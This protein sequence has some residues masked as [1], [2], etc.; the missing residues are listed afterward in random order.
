MQNVIIKKRQR[1]QQTQAT[2]DKIREA[3][4]RIGHRPPSQK[5]LKRS[6]ESRERISLSKKGFTHTLEVRKKMSE[7]RSGEK[8]HFFGKS[9]VE[10]ALI[11]MSNAKIGKR[12]SNYI[13]D[14]SKV[15]LDKDRGGPLHKEWSKSVKNRDKWKCCISNMNCKGKVVAHHIYPWALYPDL[16]YKINNGITLCRAH[17]PLKRVDEQRM[18]PLF[19]E[20]VSN[21]KL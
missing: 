10:S 2:K 4:L 19:T 3:M 21:I 13:E 1:N 17:H 9:H 7:S 20:M 18:I 8:N 14:R 11:R 12:P 16:R 6:A 5:G 15:K